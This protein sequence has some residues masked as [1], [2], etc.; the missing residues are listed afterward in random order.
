MEEITNAIQIDEMLET[1]NDTVK[2]G[3]NESKPKRRI[4]PAVNNLP[5][6]IKIM[7]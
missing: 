5:K 4:K 1:F 2:K 3:I 6:N 7:I